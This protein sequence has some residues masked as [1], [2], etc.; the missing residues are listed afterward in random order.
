MKKRQVFSIR[1]SKRIGGASVLA[2]SVFFGSLIPTSAVSAESTDKSVQ[3]VQGD[4]I[5]KEKDKVQTV[6]TENTNVLT[7]LESK[8]ADGTF[9]RTATVSSLS[10]EK[11]HELTSILIDGFNTQGDNVAF[12]DQAVPKQSLSIAEITKYLIPIMNQL[13]IERDLPVSKVQGSNDPDI[14]DR[15]AKLVRDANRL[16]LEQA[17]RE[18]TENDE[19]EAVSLETKETFRKWIERGLLTSKS[20]LTIQQLQEDL[21]A[22]YRGALLVQQQYSFEEGLSETLVFEPHTIFNKEDNHISAYDRLKKYGGTQKLDSRLGGHL[23]QS[24]KLFEERGIKEE[25]GA[26]SI[27][28]LVEKL[29]ERQNLTP[30]EY[31]EQQTEAQVLSVSGLSVYETLKERPELNYMIL[32]TLSRGKG[33]YLGVTSGSLSVGMLETYKDEQSEDVLKAHER[34]TAQNSNPFFKPMLE[35]QENYVTFLKDVNRSSQPVPF[36]VATDS[37]KHFVND[38]KRSQWSKSEGTEAA[39]AVRNYL[40]PM[41]FWSAYNNAGVGIGGVSTSP[42]SL[43]S[44]ETRLMTK[45]FKG[46]G[47]FAHEMTHGN[48]KLIIFGDANTGRRLGQGAEL[49]ARSMFETE[50]NTQDGRNYIKPMFHFNT[51]TPIAESDQRIQAKNPHTTKDSLVNYSRNLIDLIAYLEAKEAEIALSLPE[52]DR[53]TYFNQVEQVDRGDASNSTND[54]FVQATQVPQTIEDLIKNGYVSGQFFPHGQERYTTVQTNQYDYLPLFESFYG[55]NVAQEGKNT[56]GDLSF[57]RNV[58]EIMGWL[59]WDAFVTYAGGQYSSDIEAFNHILADESTQNW[60]EFKIA[61]Y[62]ELSKKTA[63]DSSLWTDDSLNKELTQAIQDDLAILK[64]GTNS[65]IYRQATNVRNVKQKILNKAL[66]YNELEKSVLQDKNSASDDDTKARETVMTIQQI[67]LDTL[68]DEKIDVNQ[69]NEFVI[70]NS[71]ELKAK[72]QNEDKAIATKIEKTL[73]E[74]V[75]GKYYI[76]FVNPKDNRSLDELV[77]TQLVITYQLDET[78]PWYTLVGDRIEV[79]G[80]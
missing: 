69:L 5:Q 56:V 6:S 49:Y 2:A 42:T 71:T 24:A 8:I 11:M 47:L 28:A 58:H 12:S 61:K 80:E 79:S 10:E 34:G 51:T 55:A 30:S 52:A 14:I 72:M 77:N 26:A 44:Y 22:L 19:F 16:A 31:F 4:T 53:L 41:K 75:T 17:N 73:K 65:V 40:H 35:G 43:Q 68:L 62:K 32:P 66:Q 3:G 9:D 57:K 21:A 78:S 74:M 45:D 50:N 1:D 63:V 23:K 37:M 64:T 7:V 48:D 29:A 18:L 13:R 59:G 36:A 76:Y 27:I 39:Y 38:S 15:N 25:T 67:I 33:I 70:S 20:D 60:Q 54:K 46:V